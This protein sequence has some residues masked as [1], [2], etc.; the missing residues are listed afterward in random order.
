MY[1]CMFKRICGC[2]CFCSGSLMDTSS[3]VAET[4]ASCI[5]Q[6][7]CVISGRTKMTR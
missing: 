2:V 7:A 5:G 4:L 6:I 3:L 1:V